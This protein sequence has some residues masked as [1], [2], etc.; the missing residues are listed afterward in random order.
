VINNEQLVLQPIKIHRKL[1]NP[2]D[3]RTSSMSLNKLSSQRGNRQE[4]NVSINNSVAVNHRR[5]KTMGENENSYALTAV[6]P[7]L[8]LSE[9]K[10]N[11]Q[12]LSNK[13]ENKKN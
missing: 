10:L 7:V 8:N 12:S 2:Q 11:H 4:R 3:S 6:A 13:I 9:V 1:E 5:E